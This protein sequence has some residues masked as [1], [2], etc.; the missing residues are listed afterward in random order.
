[1]NNVKF[2][3]RKTTGKTPVP[4]HLIFRYNGAVLNYN[5][6]VK[7]QPDHWNKEQQKATRKQKNYSDFNNYL[8]KL[9][10]HL[11]SLYLQYKI[12]GVIPTNAQLK[13]I[14]D[15]FT[16]NDKKAVDVMTFNKFIDVFIEGRKTMVESGTMKQYTTF[17]NLFSKYQADKKKTFDF[18]DFDFQFERNFKAYHIEKSY[19][20]N[21]TGKNIKVL[22]SILNEAAK[23]G[24]NK[25]TDFDTFKKPQ[26]NVD[27][28]YLN[29]SD[30]E[31][32]R[33]CILEPH[34]D[35]IRDIFLFSCNTG[36]RHSDYSKF[37][38]DKHL[39][40][41]Y[42]DTGEAYRVIVITTQKTG[43][44]VEIPT[45][46][47]VE[48]ILAKYK[49]VLPKVNVIQDINDAIK[50]IG[51]L[52]GVTDDVIVTAKIGNT[53]TE[54]KYAKYQLITT[55]TGRRSFCTNAFKEGAPV[56]NLMKITGHQSEA[57]FF[58][59]LKIDSQENALLLTNNAFFN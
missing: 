32:I 21:Y 17:K 9:A 25:K 38:S 41:R 45:N 49:D 22:K 16:N 4:V 55:H 3:L 56:A 57:M 39:V 7:I 28:I 15:D 14:L 13:T 18:D 12:K 23:H 19:S 47:L 53:R 31:K 36:L 27:K 20:T 59:Y 50:E 6:G 29:K 11:E 33:T 8:N 10:E 52:A 30:L 26:E 44:K 1:M 40:T 35:R 48:S 58:K 2:N 42:H 5:T 54:T 43:E 24:Y 46:S 37:D 34:H 51:K